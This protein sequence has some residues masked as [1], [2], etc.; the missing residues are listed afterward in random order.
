MKYMN[1][2]REACFSGESL[3]RVKY[4]KYLGI[5]FSQNINFNEHA[6]YILGIAAFLYIG[7]F[8]SLSTSILLNSLNTIGTPITWNGAEIWFPN[9]NQDT[10]SKILLDDPEKDTE[11]IFINSEH[12]LNQMLMNAQLKS[13]ILKLF[14]RISVLLK[15][16]I[17]ECWRIPYSLH[18]ATDS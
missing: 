12:E 11:F 2:A 15:K 17:D 10:I 16:Q 6:H 9:L 3:E 4:Y 13:R 1:G 18:F 7:R 14:T 5:C 8:H